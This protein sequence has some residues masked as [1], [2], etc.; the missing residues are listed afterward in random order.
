MIKRKKSLV[1]V[2]MVIIVL[3]GGYLWSLGMEQPPQPFDKTAPPTAP[4]YSRAQDW[5][6]FPGRNGFERS[7]PMG[8]IPIRE[9]DAVADVFFIHPTTYLKNDVWNVPVDAHTRY[10]VPVLL[11]QASAFNGCCRIYAPHYR[12]ATL[13]ALNDS[14]PAV[15]L[16]FGDVER[17]F[18]R[19]LAN[20]NHG[21][22]FI[23]ASHSQGSAHAVRLLQQD[24]LGTPA[25]HQLIAAYVIGAFVP[26]DF[27]TLGL[28]V[29]DSAQATGCIVSWNT[30]QVG[31]RGSERLIH[32]TNY[33]WRGA[34]KST[35]LPAAVCVNPLNWRH[36]GSA[37]ASANLGSVTLLETVDDQ[38]PAMPI[39]LQAATPAL[40]G[41]ACDQGLLAVDVPPLKRGYSSLLRV[42][43]GSFH[44]LDYGMFY[45]NI[46][47]NAQQRTRAWQEMAAK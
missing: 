26:S 22:P 15:D 5:L 17:A 34:W 37:P 14:R 44:V 28:P 23:L 38:S 30:A 11:N 29:C 35:G 6:A 10:G 41:A 32:E 3:A 19:Y 25:Q 13:K 12:Q 7:A 42:V 27:P 8:D 47:Q 36:E 46:R 1:L 33:W 16:A 31:R 21:R 2:T 45:E 39:V 20:E 18:R 40:T 4:D 43:Y 9:E 24:I